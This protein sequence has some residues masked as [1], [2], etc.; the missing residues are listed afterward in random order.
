[1]IRIKFLA[2]FLL[3]AL[4]LSV[5]PGEVI[6]QE[7]PL[8][9]IQV[10]G[11]IILLEPGQNVHPQ[12]HALLLQ[13]PDFASRM[14]WIFMDGI[15][16]PLSRGVE[17][18]V[19]EEPLL[20]E[21]APPSGPEPTPDY[22]PECRVTLN[23][24]VYGQCW[25][26]WGSSR[27]FNEPTC[28]TMCAQGCAITSA[29]MVFRYYGGSKDPGQVNS[30]LGEYSCR[31]GCLLTWGCAASNCSDNKA[32][33]VGY[34][35]FYWDALCGLLNLGRPPIVKLVKGSSTHFVVVYNSLG[36]SIPDPSGY[37]IN[38]PADGSTYKTLYYYTSNGWSPS[39]IAE[40]SQR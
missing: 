39:M 20:S 22:I 8:V 13:N 16:I 24:P 36:Y 6:G 35:S 30:C 26:P 17:G 29:T 38:D 5:G 31:S 28:S 27:L 3:L 33:Y 7:A 4:L 40:Y 37:R 21:E 11:Q 23:V 25:S 2:T 34:Y 12:T 15:W 10:N 19:A 9:P 1:M 18:P 14:D 32:T